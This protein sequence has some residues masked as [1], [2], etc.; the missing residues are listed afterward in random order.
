[1]GLWSRI[2]QNFATPKKDAMKFLIVGLGNP[3]AQYHYNRHNIGFM[4]LDHLVGAQEKV[5]F[6]SNSSFSNQ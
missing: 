4:V 6:T 1:M 3:G 2:W 5:A